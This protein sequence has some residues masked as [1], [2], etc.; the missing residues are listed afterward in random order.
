MPLHFSPSLSAFSEYFRI[1]SYSLS[2]SSSPLWFQWAYSSCKKQLLKST[3]ESSTCSIIIFSRL[4][5]NPL[6]KRKVKKENPFL[7]F[8]PKCLLLHPCWFVSFSH[9]LP[10]ISFSLQPVFS[11]NRFPVKASRW[12]PANT[13]PPTRFRPFRFKPKCKFATWTSPTSSSAAFGRLAVGTWTGAGAVRFSL[14]GFSLLMHAPPWRSRLRHRL[15]RR[16]CRWCRTTR[17]NVWTR[18]R[19]RCWVGI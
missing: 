13:H 15:R 2:S 1:F 3:F 18:C 8:F 4:P 6:A 11:S 12:S 7:H 5:N 16:T 14:R 19:R 17:R 10:R 9:A